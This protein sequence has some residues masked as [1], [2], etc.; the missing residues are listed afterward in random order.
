MD[1]NAVI[2]ERKRLESILD[3]A[4]IPTQ[5]RNA[6]SPVLD[7]MAWQRVKLDETRELM[8][9]AQV[10]CEYNNG[11]GQSG[12]R[13]NPIFKGYLELWRGYMLGLEKLTSYLSNDLQDEITGDSASI[14]EQVRNMKKGKK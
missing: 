9:N 8:K 5:Q 4:D 3:K 11:G 6:L 7:N 13:Q 14:L 12:I 2:E 1:E 10:V